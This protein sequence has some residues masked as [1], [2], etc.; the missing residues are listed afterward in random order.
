MSSVL[1]LNIVCP[2]SFPL[3]INS[4]EPPELEPLLSDIIYTVSLSSF[5]S[6]ITLQRDLV[7][8]DED[9]NYLMFLALSS[10]AFVLASPT[11]KIF[12]V[13]KSMLI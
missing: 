1:V 5:L 7:F 9:L 8:H 11:S 3:L 13:P 6:Q 4:S 12:D 2:L 10:M